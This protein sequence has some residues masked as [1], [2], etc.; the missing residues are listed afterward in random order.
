[1]TDIFPIVSL[2]FDGFDLS[3]KKKVEAIFKKF[4]ALAPRFPTN[5]SSVLLRRGLQILLDLPQDFI[6]NRSATH[7]FRMLCSLCYFEKKLKNPSC[8]I[9]DQ[10]LLVRILK[11]PE[12]VNKEPKPTLAILA[13]LKLKKETEFFQSTYVLRAIKRMLPGVREIPGTLYMHWDQKNALISFYIEVKKVRGD[14]FS[15]QDYHQIC[16]IF[17]DELLESIS[18]ISPPLVIPQNDEEIYR[19]LL[20]LSHELKWVR[21]LPQVMITFQ[22]QHENSLRFALLI[23]RVLKKSTPPMQQQMAK[24]PTSVHTLSHYVS[25]VG[26]L[27]KKYPKEAHVL[28]LQMDYSLFLRKNHAVDLRKARHYL[29]KAAELM[30]GPFRDFNGGFL[31]KQHEQLECIKTSLQ[32][33]NQKQTLLLEQLFYSL[34]PSLFQAFIS[35]EACKQWL[36]LFLEALHKN[37]H[38]DKYALFK[39]D[40]EKFSLAIIKTPFVKLKDVVIEEM[41]KN[42]SKF[43]IGYSIQEKE[44]FCYVSFIFQTP[45]D[46]QLNILLEKILCYFS[47][48]ETPNTISSKQIL[49]LNFQEGDPPSLHPHISIDI[50]GNTLGNALFEGLMRNGINGKPKPAAAQDIQI[51][52]CKKYYQFHLRAMK[53]SNGEEMTAYHFEKAWKKA[54]TPFSHCLRSELFYPIKNAKK[55]HLGQVPFHD[56]GVRCLSP[57]ILEV[58]LEHPAPYF[59]ELLI[60]PIFSPLYEDHGEPSIFNGPFVLREWKQ[61]QK[62]IL[63]QNP[64]YWD[65][66]KINLKGIEIFLQKVP[67]L[68]L[69]MFEEKKIDWI[70]SPFSLLPLETGRRL[71]KE[72]ILKIKPILGIYYLHCNTKF[73]LLSSSK[74]RQ[75]LSYAINREELCEKVLLGQ[76]PCYGH[77]PKELSQI[78]AEILNDN[79][80]IKK[81]RLL[82][83]EGLEETKISSNCIPPLV[84]IHARIGGQ[85]QLAKFLKN[86]WEQAFLIKVQTIEVEWNTLS[87]IFD[88]RQFQIGGCY[89]NFLYKSPLYLF[90]LLKD[91]TNYLNASGWHNQRFQEIIECMNNLEKEKEFKQFLYLAEN[92]LAN[93]MPIIPLYR[94]TF[95]YSHKQEL[96]GFS[97]SN[98]GHVDFK[99]AFL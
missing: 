92:L 46:S 57:K 15:N 61:D 44:G 16:S 87:S 93:E 2:F 31:S 40:E 98:L 11:D 58:E 83:R 80:K 13:V 17:R 30:I 63:D 48:S 52:P 10:N 43:Q 45:D 55:A 22:E 37:L 7:L 21:D 34:T 5:F 1:M 12:V 39:K 71:K 70:G 8:I 90:N 77:L 53:W 18:T 97:F 41:G 86:Q 81:A 72:N 76:R 88:K 60:D 84:F 6:Q 67:D 25:Q 35:P 95:Y 42:F 54:I 59:L 24:L 96:N 19:N 79:D 56:V 28:I 65:I 36:A 94:D 68:V 38:P 20:R 32:N 9:E 91:S 29:A 14:G 89:R 51:S 27:R 3:L 85:K 78:D 50:R 23:V 82:F 47:T 74:I 62:I 4:E 69:G 66:N 64:Y 26:H 75:A 73:P 99:Y 49:R 33:T